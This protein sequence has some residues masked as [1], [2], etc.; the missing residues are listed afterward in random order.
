MKK[1]IPYTGAAN[2]SSLDAFC[3]TNSKGCY[4]FAKVLFSTTIITVS[5]KLLASNYA[6]SDYQFGYYKDGK[7]C[8]WSAARQIACQNAGMSRG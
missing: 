3:K 5:D 4:L 1:N 2:K 8:D 6:P 7:H